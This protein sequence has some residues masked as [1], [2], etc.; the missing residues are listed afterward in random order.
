MPRKK[1]DG[2]EEDKTA[3]TLRPPNVSGS[4]S[5]SDP[6]P[7]AAPSPH[8]PHSL[9]TSRFHLVA[10]VWTGMVVGFEHFH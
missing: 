7:N 5:P 6:Q 8:L 3:A 9:P 10:P 1:K 2:D 4:P